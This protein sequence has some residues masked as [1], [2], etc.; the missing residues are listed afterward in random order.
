MKTIFKASLILTVLISS[1][2]AQS[3]E[4]LKLRLDQN[5]D[6]SKPLS[7]NIKIETASSTSRAVF[8]ELPAGLKPVLSSARQGENTFW[9]FNGKQEITKDNVLGWY[10]QDN[11]LVLHYTDKSGELEIELV[12]D[13]SR[14][15]RFE[16]I[17]V[18]IYSVSKTGQNFEIE[19]TVLAQSN[20]SVKKVEK[21]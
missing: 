13:E 5:E 11:G 1:L 19:K 15:K 18:K 9:L 16:D 3:P 10:A 20:I 17:D 4:I 6:Q 7:L 8:V 2:F 21:E 12:P 14:I